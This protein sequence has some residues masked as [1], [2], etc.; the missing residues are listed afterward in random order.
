[1][2]NRTSFRLAPKQ[3]FILFGFSVFFLAT[4][5]GSSLFGQSL[6]APSVIAT[7]GGRIETATMTLDW[8]LGETFVSDSKVDDRRFTEGFHQPVLTVETVVFN[9][10]A[11]T[12]EKLKISKTKSVQNVEDRS[13]P[14]ISE[15][16]ADLAI[17]IWPNPV[18]EN[19]TVRISSGELASVQLELFDAQ[20]NLLEHNNS[21][22]VNSAFEMAMDA[23]PNGF[24]FI[25]FLAPDG[26][27]L[28][29]RKITLAR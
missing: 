1:M 28:G 5:F 27:S 29:S 6:L 16:V 26:Q 25:R 18:C 10:A 19:L 7:G 17:A 12:A 14:P 24:Y 20:G 2:D 9:P 8:T 21:L 3:P 11:T 13:A 15:T 23:R 22:P 4:F